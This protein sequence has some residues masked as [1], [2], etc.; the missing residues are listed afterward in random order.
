MLF[1]G[2]QKPPPLR[3]SNL[4]TAPAT[5]H[6]RRRFFVFFS[7]PALPLALGTQ[8][9]RWRSGSGYQRRRGGP[10]LVVFVSGSPS[11]STWNIN[12]IILKD[13]EQY[14]NALAWQDR[15]SWT[16][17]RHKWDSRGLTPSVTSSACWRGDGRSS[18]GCSCWGVRGNSSG[19]HCSC[20]QWLDK[21]SES[22]LWR[23]QNFFKVCVL[24]LKPCCRNIIMWQT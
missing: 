2:Q 3:S 12:R 22:M 19:R 16:G 13:K 7:A 14:R 10:R 18:V 8:A 1:L 15:R 9:T 23:L 4:F 17:S 21:W 11:C 24:N 6:S 20:H 5:A